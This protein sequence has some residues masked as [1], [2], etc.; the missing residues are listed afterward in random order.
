MPLRLFFLFCSASLAADENYN[1]ETTSEGIVDKLSGE[2]KAQKTR[3]LPK[4]EG[5][6]NAF[7]SDEPEVKPKV[8][9]RGLTRSIKVARK[10]KGKE[11]EMNKGN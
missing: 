2:K 1:F 6:S 11:E 4:E 8:K 9:T 7:E 3:S 10:D 5:W